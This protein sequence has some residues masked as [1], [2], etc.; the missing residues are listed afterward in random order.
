MGGLGLGP[1]Q[2]GF[3]QSWAPA[4][5]AQDNALPRE[6]ESDFGAPITAGNRFPDGTSKETPKF[7]DVDVRIPSHAG[8]S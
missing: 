1:F 3:G 8:H 4:L 6:G 7:V 5:E 2:K